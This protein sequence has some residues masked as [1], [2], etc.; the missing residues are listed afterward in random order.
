MSDVHVTLGLRTVKI[1]EA[2]KKIFLAL[3]FLQTIVKRIMK[4]P[5]ESRAIKFLLHSDAADVPKIFTLLVHTRVAGSRSWQHKTISVLF[6]DM[7]VV[8]LR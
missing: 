5:S 2:R 7:S 6:V 4:I 8:D 1:T 3:F